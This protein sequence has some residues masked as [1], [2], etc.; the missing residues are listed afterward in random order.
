MSGFLVA[1]E[2][3]I[4]FAFLAGMLGACAVF[5]SV[6]PARGRG[7][8]RLSRWPTNF[9]LMGEA[10]AH[11]WTALCLPFRGAVSR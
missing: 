3:N 5:E 7:Q 6:A 1:H 2:A 4:R 10:P 9:I 8:S 11:V